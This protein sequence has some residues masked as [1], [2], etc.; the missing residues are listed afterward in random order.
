MILPPP[1]SQV[2][3]CW[4]QENNSCKEAFHWQNCLIYMS[5]IIKMFKLKFGS[6]HHNWKSVSP[7]QWLEFCAL[8]GF[9]CP[10]ED[11]QRHEFWKVF[12]NSTWYFH[13]ETGLGLSMFGG[14]LPLMLLKSFLLMISADWESQGKPSSLFHASDTVLGL[15]SSRDRWG[16]AQGVV[17][18]DMKPATIDQL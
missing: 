13:L 18:W 14:A 9:F 3:S 16:V 11:G 7:I 12:L 10:M 1:H 17:S 4:D 8:I 2:Q 6:K 15:R 5:R